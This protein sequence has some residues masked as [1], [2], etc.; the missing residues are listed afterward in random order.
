GKLLESDR[1]LT[2]TPMNRLNFFIVF[3]LSI[4]I[5]TARAQEPFT[6]YGN[7]TEK[8]Y[9]FVSVN[10]EDH[11]IPPTYCDATGFSEGLASVKLDGKWGYIDVNQKTR[12]AFSF[13]Y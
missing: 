5:M 2:F 12:I 13:D 11:N 4:S 3:L 1:L 8:T 9:G 7:C 6:S 10:G